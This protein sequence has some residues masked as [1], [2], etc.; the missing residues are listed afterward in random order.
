MKKNKIKKL[1]CLA[2]TKFLNLYDAEYE[3]KKGK[4]K[5]WIIAS[6]KNEE[7]LKNCY[8]DNIPDHTDAVVIAALHEESGSL[9]VIRQFRVPL[10]EY[11]YEL[12]A[13]LIDAEED[14]RCALNREL[15]EETGLKVTGVNEKLSSQKAYLSSGM[16]DESAAFIYCSCEGTI[17]KDYLEEDE[18]IEAFLVSQE[19]ARDLLDSGAKMD[20]KAFIILNSFA[21]LGKDLF[22]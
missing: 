7:T 4:L 3:N 16:T 13:G 10:N 6:R 22:A 19:E 8:F 2:E 14:I 21:K 11:V 12:P 20:I 18:D 1:I 5:H 17:T 9:V 15:E